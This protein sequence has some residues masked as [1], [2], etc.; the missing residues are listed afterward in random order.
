MRTD[1]QT[2]T[3]RQN[4]SSLADVIKHFIKS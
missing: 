3:Q 1:R 4:I 2:N